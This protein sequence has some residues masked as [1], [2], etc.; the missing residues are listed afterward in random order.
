MFWNW[1][2]VL[3]NSDL[4]QLRNQ[5]KPFWSNFAV[6]IS[7]IFI[8]NHLNYLCFLCLQLAT[9]W[10]YCCTVHCWTALS[11]GIKKIWRGKYY[12]HCDYSG[13]LHFQ[14][15]SWKIYNVLKGWGGGLWT[16]QI[17]PKLTQP[18]LH[19]NFTQGATLLSTHFV[20][21]NYF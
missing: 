6:F 14:I 9:T 11:T 16:K 13:I 19:F 7:V 4:Y 21:K 18:Q 15:K 1:R 3:N 2:K 12:T 20:Y 5:T 8:S 17:T 10:L